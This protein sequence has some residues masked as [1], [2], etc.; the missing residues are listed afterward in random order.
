MN[1]ELQT[2]ARYNDRLVLECVQLKEE[3]DAAKREAA[4]VRIAGMTLRDY[5]A[6]HAP[7][8]VLTSDASVSWDQEIRIAC[9]DLGVSR[10]ESNF[11]NDSLG[12]WCRVDAFRRYRY[13]D[14]MLDARSGGAK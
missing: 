10:A 9:K 3:L 4:G 14:A 6:A 7:A 5:F 2:M 8:Q 11:D 12:F 1:E 13:A